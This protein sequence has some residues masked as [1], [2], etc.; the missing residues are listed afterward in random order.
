LACVSLWYRNLAQRSRKVK[1]WS[2][3]Y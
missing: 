2:K 3:K 1:H